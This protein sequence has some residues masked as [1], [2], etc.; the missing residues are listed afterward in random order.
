[1]LLY[2]SKRICRVLDG[3]E[4]VSSLFLHCLSILLALHPVIILLSKSSTHLKSELV[5]KG[6][7]IP[8]PGNLKVLSLFL[9]QILQQEYGSITVIW[10]H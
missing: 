9:F 10:E 5:T 4:L 2:W 3:K 6:K 8:F 1:M 7:I